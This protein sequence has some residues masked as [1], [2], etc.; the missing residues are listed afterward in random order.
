MKDK[1]YPAFYRSTEGYD[2]L[3]LDAANYYAFANARWR[4]AD[5]ID[6]LD[7]G[8]D[9]NV[10]REYLQTTWGVVES[11]EHAEFII[12]IAEIAGL[13]V[14]VDSPEINRAFFYI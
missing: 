2:Y 3:Y 14:Y 1:I 6:V 10:N 8:N 11:K 4:K 9:I 13:E 5:G 7:H 12:E